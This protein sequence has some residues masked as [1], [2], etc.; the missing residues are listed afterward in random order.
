[1][2]GCGVLLV[3]LRPPRTEKEA[4]TQIGSV[5]PKGKELDEG[6]TL[7]WVTL[8]ICVLVVLGCEVL[9]AKLLPPNAE[10]DMLTQIRSLQP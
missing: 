4:L 1:M 6:P 10:M 9:V 7:C 2:L 5:Q 8:V 3:K